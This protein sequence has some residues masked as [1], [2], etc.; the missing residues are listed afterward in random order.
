MVAS[1]GGIQSVLGS[2]AKVEQ[3]SQHLDAGQQ[4]TIAVLQ[5]QVS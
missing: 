1:L 2:E 5:K 4:I 3:V